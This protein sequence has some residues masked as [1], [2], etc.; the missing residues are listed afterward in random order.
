ML[1]AALTH[2]A[3]CHHQRGSQRADDSALQFFFPAYK[4]DTVHIRPP[5]MDH[6][7]EQVEAFVQ[8]LHTASQREKKPLV[9]STH[10]LLPPGDN[11]P[12]EH[13]I[14]SWKAQ[15]FAYRQFSQ[16]REE[17]PTLARGLFTEKVNG[18]YERIVIRGYDK[19]FNQD[20]LA[21]T[22]P[23]AIATYSTGPFILSFKE[24]GCIIFISAIT[25]KR[26]IVTSK[27]SLGFRTEGDKPTHAEMGWHWVRHHLA[28]AGRSEEALANELWNRN[29]T[30]VFELC[31]D[32]FEEHVLPYSPERTGLHLH[33]LN[34]NTVDFETRPM[35]E[36]KAFAEAWGFF[37]VRYLTF[38]THEEVD[39]FT[40]SVALTGSLNG[41]PIEGFVV[42]TTI[43]DDISNPPPGVVPPP[44]KPGQTWFY[45]IKFDEPYLMYR[46]WR[47]LTRTMLR[48]KNNWDALQLALLDSQTKHLEIE[49][50]EPEEKQEPQEHDL[51]APSKNAM[52]R[53]QRALR[54]KKDELDRKTGVAKPWAPT[55]KS[56]RPETMLYVLWCYDRIYGNPQQN[57]APQPELF[58]EFG[59]GRGIIS[60]REAFL[61]YLASEDGQKALSD[62]TQSKA[63][64]T[65]DLRS[66]ERP[67]EKTL[68]VPIAVPGSGKTA[69]FV[70]LSHL[71]GWAHTQ[72]DD[73]QTKRTGPGFLKNVEKE[74]L[75][76]D[77][78][79]A[80]RNNH[81]IKHR[82]E[83]VDIVRR[84]SNPQRG[85]V[86]RV[87]LCAIVWD[88]AGLP[89]SEIQALCSKRM[90]DRGD[91]HQCLRIE[92]PGKFEYD[93][94]LTRFI[95][96]TQPFR[97]AQ[98][99]EGSVG[100]SDDQ[101]D[102]VVRLDIHD[103]MKVSL[104]RVLKHLCPVLG[105]SMPTDELISEA[106]DVAMHYRPS[107]RKPLPKLESDQDKQ[108]NLAVLPSSYLGVSVFMTPSEFVLQLLDRKPVSETVLSARRILSIIINENRMIQ[109]PHMTIVHQ[110]D[111]K[112][113]IVDQ[114]AWDKL[115]TFAIS[116]PAVNPR[117]FLEVTALLWNH[118]VMALEVSPPHCP[119]WKDTTKFSPRERHH[120]TIGTAELSA[121]AFEANKLWDDPEA[122]RLEVPI[123]RLE[124]CLKFYSNRK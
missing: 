79:L 56:R 68:I 81:L 12:I 46:D 57:V 38:Q 114:A 69:L 112:K 108:K 36:V 21:W 28:Q 90:I 62:K 122:E 26:L 7:N 60:L 101:F 27:H 32:S 102:E 96:E 43:P 50:Q 25:P 91:R 78:V 87:R 6:R 104:Q 18:Q 15:E 116:D 5:Y 47:E 52:K 124:G 71:F 39:A 10:F 53:A 24:N 93:V 95:K 110:Q 31:D 64:E 117:V 67:Y 11:D 23:N 48:E 41:E 121:T 16:D 2:V 94:I 51:A 59:Q 89:H 13:N 55:P 76:H 44:Y 106:I 82:D 107:V 22:L 49:D 119:D 74:L 19:F 113:G 99:G 70:A 1:R 61:A 35:V 120:I 123:Q 14:L 30:A 54:R 37:P 8:A 80:D 9:R 3:T 40:K 86:G 111:V 103:P 20:E 92:T 45:K 84:I 77:V 98:S 73:V 33:G 17:L 42:R 109:R 4:C 105:L 63:S 85:S 72:S 65:R 83:L 97:G 75:A 118:R 29:E 88:I 115:Y 34:K 58:A 100:V 66:D